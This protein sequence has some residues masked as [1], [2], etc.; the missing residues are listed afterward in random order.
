VLSGLLP[1]QLQDQVGEA[2]DHVGGLRVARVGVDHAVD[3]QPRGH[4]IQIAERALEAAQDRQGGGTGGLLRGLQR[5]LAGD[6]AE[7]PAERSV[8]RQRAMAGHERSATGDTDPDKREL[9]AGWGRC[10]RW[11]LQSKV[12][13]A[14]FDL[15][16][17]SSC[18][19]HRHGGKV[20]VSMLPGA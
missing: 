6:L 10:R 12:R 20:T 19:C 4:P 15:H 14:L 7:G 13:Q 16:A 1:I 9:E 5:D 3:H 2:V 18:A 8:G 11:E 17:T